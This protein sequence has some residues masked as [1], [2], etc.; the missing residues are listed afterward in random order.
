[1]RKL[2]LGFLVGILCSS[3]AWGV[4]TRRIDCEFDYCIEDLEPDRYSET[5]I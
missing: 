3:I 5:S 2:M 1:M 4:A